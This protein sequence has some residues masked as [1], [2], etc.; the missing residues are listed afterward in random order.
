RQSFIVLHNSNSR[1]ACNDRPEEERA[2]KPKIHIQ[3]SAAHAIA[4][5]SFFSK[6]LTGGWRETQD[7]RNGRIEIDAEDWDLDAFLIVLHAMHHHVAFIINAGGLPIP[8]LIISA[9][10]KS[11]VAAIEK[12]LL[13]IQQTREEYLT[14]IRGCRFECSS[15]MYVS[16]TRRVHSS[17]LLSP[18]PVAPYLGLSYKRFIQ[19]IGSFRSPWWAAFSTSP[20]LVSHTCPD[21]YF[22]C[23]FL[24]LYNSG[25][26]L[27]LPPTT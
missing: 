11:R 22:G 4:A 21:S 17:Q 6:A 12:V 24:D 1:T 15:I 16:L 14:G 27:D 13:R 25:I 10:N 19:E 23:L 26:G 9:M 5:C 7:L 18:W 3:I 20:P 2:D 8:A